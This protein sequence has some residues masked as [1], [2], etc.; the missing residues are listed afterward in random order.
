MRI[1]ENVELELIVNLELVDRC[2]RVVIKL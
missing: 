2:K 1:A